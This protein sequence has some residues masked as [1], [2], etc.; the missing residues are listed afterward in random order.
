MPTELLHHEKQILERMLEGSPLA[1][2]LGEICLAIERLSADRVRASILLLDADE[3]R[4][5][6]GA[7]PSLPEEYSRALEGREIGPTAGSCG[8]AAFTRRQ[9]VTSEIAT[10]PLWE[11]YRDLALPHGL[12]ACW[13]TPLLGG[14]GAVLGTFALYYG[15]PR[16][17]SP[18]DERIVDVLTRLAV[19]AIERA[20]SDER[21][22]Q[23]ERDLTDFLENALVGIHSVDRNGT[24]VW[25][26]RA[27]LELYGYA[28]DEYVGRNIAEFHVEAERIEQLLERLRRGEGV[29]DVECPVR[30]KDGSIKHVLVSSNAVFV[31]GELA[32][33]RCFTRDITDRKR[34][35]VALAEQ[36]RRKDEFLAMLGHELRNPLSAL[37]SSLDVLESRSGSSD[38]LGV[39]RRQSGHLMRL[40]D[41]LL[42]LS[43]VTRGKIEL[44]R[45]PLDVAVA[46]QRGIELVRPLLAERSQ[47]VSLERAG[48]AIVDG[49]LVRLAQVFGNVLHNAAKFSPHGARI[50]VRAKR[51]ARDVVVTVRDPGAGIGC[52]LL[53]HVFEPFVQGEVSRDR[54]SAGLG[55]GL[56]LV[57]ALVE[58]HGGA[59]SVA[60]AGRGL[61]TEV[62]VRLPTTTGA[63]IGAPAAVHVEPPALGGRV[64]L[65]E[66]NE[67]VARS[68]AALLRLVGFEVT[69]A[70]D[71]PAALV[72]A[73]RTAY[74]VF[75][76]DIGLPG[77]DGLEV[78]RQLKQRAGLRGAR[79]VALTGYGSDADRVQ[80]QEAGFDA[81]LVKPATLDAL[82]AAL[83]P[84]Q[85]G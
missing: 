18:Q 68:L 7:A 44:R 27:E 76:V 61:G 1:A 6:R 13:S 12:R 26:N 77:M 25:A 70:A 29:R 14:N 58:L 52:E 28:R 65:V 64:L 22:R 83:T 47:T 20:R 43:R 31:G 16:L 42:D 35:E 79:L 24:I 30:A 36:A 63:P 80:S 82:V 55:I 39:M 2:T 21:L 4:L 9:V 62:T 11:G 50:D 40:V 71:G 72:E 49:D 81:H 69:V 5:R 60:S 10:D 73:G 23:R 74:D 3:R 48:P 38:E 33:T 54:E 37:Q 67:D 46:V 59:V 75:V 34:A 41:D 78:A 17:P 51:D 57:R 56:S 8:T 45:E 53:P 19:L 84:R 66:D 15:S 32:R 85:P